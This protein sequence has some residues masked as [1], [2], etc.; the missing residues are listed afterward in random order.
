MGPVCPPGCVASWSSGGQPHV[1]HVIRGRDMSWEGVVRACWHLLSSSCVT[2][3]CLACARRSARCCAR[4]SRGGW[5]IA[6]RLT[7][8]PGGSGGGLGA[9]WRRR[10]TSGWQQA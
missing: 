4:G 10:C 2:L 1:C 6:A 7:G 8:E 5:R 3:A 9:A